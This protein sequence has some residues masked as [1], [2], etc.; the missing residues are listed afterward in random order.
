LGNIAKEHLNWFLG[1]RENQK[2]L[3]RIAL[4][5]PVTI[6]IKQ[7]ATVNQTKPPK[8]DHL[9]EYYTYS[10]AKLK[11]LTL[12]PDEWQHLLDIES[13]KTSQRTTVI[14]WLNAQVEVMIA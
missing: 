14:N 5:E 2:P 11:T 1:L 3:F 9:V 4:A 7:A 10:L 8:Y 6:T 12:Q 13:G